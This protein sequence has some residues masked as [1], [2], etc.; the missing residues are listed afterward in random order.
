M[1][2][3]PE[4]HS[5]RAQCIRANG[6]RLQVRFAVTELARIRGPVTGARRFDG[7]A[8]V[9][10]KGAVGERDTDRFMH[11]LCLAQD[12]VV[13]PGSSGFIAPDLA[14]V[15]QCYYIRDNF[16]ER[17]R[18]MVRETTIRAVGNSAGMTI[19]KAVLDRYRLAAG[20]TVFLVETDEGV[21]VTPYDP[22]FKEA[23]AIYEEGARA[24][25]N[26]MHDL[27]SR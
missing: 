2:S 3:Q 23:M 1:K 18:S 13:G 5:S 19:P 4:S 9:C 20:D 12:Q 7:V 10:E 25:R 16:P 26:A 27:S 6:N 21:L 22:S 11:G 24:Y 14:R 8:E 17:G 15:A